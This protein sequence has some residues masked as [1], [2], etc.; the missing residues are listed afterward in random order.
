MFLV[1]LHCCQAALSAEI[2]NLGKN[3]QKE[4]HEKPPVTSSEHQSQSAEPS[5][6][7]HRFMR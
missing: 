6:D 1:L 2:T 3:Y 4:L 7:R 5:V